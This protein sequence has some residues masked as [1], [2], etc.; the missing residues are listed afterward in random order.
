MPV[1]LKMVQNV[2]ERMQRGVKEVVLCDTKLADEDVALLAAEVKKTGDIC[3]LSLFGCQV[4]ESA[5]K[6]LA[7]ALA[8]HQ[9]LTMLDLGRNKLSALGVEAVCNALIRNSSLKTLGLAGNGMGDSGA[10][11]V[12]HVLR[13]NRSLTEVYLNSNDIQAEGASELAGALSFNDHSRLSKLFMHKNPLGPEGV[14]E[15]QKFL[16]DCPKAEERVAL[17]D[18]RALALAMGTHARLGAKIEGNNRSGC[19]RMLGGLSAEPPDAKYAKHRKSHKDLLLKIVREC[20][21]YRLVD[22]QI[23]GL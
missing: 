3:S 22:R 10:T 6:S 4:S 2:V 5:A 20:S 11:A 23:I 8:S 13:I 21:Q 16:E 15:L 19:L 9:S 17:D 18:D 14:R 1:K 12:A 7:N